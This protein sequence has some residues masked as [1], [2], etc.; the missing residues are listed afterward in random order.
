MQMNEFDKKK[1]D[2]EI[3]SIRKLSRELHEKFDDLDRRT[4]ERLAEMERQLDVYRLVLRN[5]EVEGCEQYI[6]KETAA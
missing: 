3:E 2:I 5:A 6:T 1:W 4:A